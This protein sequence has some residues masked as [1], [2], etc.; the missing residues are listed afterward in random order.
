MY[1]SFMAGAESAW[2]WS[3]IRGLALVRNE[4]PVRSLTAA[5]YG[6]R[7]E[8]HP[9]LSVLFDVF[10]DIITLG[11]TAFVTKLKLE[12]L[13]LLLLTIHPIAD[14]STLD[15]L[16]REPELRNRLLGCY[17]AQNKAGHT[18]TTCTTSLP[19]CRLYQ[20]KGFVEVN[21]TRNR[22]CCAV[23][24]ECRSGG[25]NSTFHSSLTLWRMNRHHV[26]LPILP[27]QAA[28][29]AADKK[30]VVIDA[31]LEEYNAARKAIE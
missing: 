23:C 1:L 27:Q 24:W 28:H 19:H 18:K 31:S 15:V 22:A 17:Y 9:I 14:A 20:S 6:H 26:T 11:S 25:A 30:A 7:T 5:F 13:V 2:E 12:W 8:A 10:Q 29:C 4:I 21:Q 3:Q 16:G